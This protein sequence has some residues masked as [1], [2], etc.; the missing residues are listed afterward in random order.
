VKINHAILHGGDEGCG[1]DTF[2]FPFIWSVCGPDLRNRGLV[3]ADGINSRWGYALE[4]EILILNE[5][6]E[7]EAA[8]RRSLEQ[9]DERVSQA[10][11]TIRPSVTTSYSNGRQRTRFDADQWNVGSKFGWFGWRRTGTTPQTSQKAN[12]AQPHCITRRHLH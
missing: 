12:T 5:L 3:D 2:W 4:S 7:P 1:K 8:Q 10:I 11:S 9:S 6:K